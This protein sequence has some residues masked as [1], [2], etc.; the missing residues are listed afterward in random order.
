M[1]ELRT[2]LLHETNP[3]R[4][5]PCGDSAVSVEFGD[6]IDETIN[7]RVLAFDRQITKAA[8]PGIVECVPTYRALLIHYDPLQ[9]SYDAL[10]GHIASCV[11]NKSATALEQGRLWRVPVVYGGE[12]GP[13]LES[14][15]QACGS[16]SHDVINLH[17]SAIYRV[18]MLGF[19]PGFAYLGGLPQTLHLP[20]RA[21]P[22]AKAEAGTISIAAAQAAI[23]CLAG[24]TGWHVIGR[25]PVRNFMPSR[26]P[27]FLFE[28]G[29]RITF[30]AV[31]Q[32]EWEKL[33]ARAQGGAPVAELVT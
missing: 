23:Q 20:R 33:A 8:L 24:P 28:P 32:S 7:S 10:C 31:D 25:T 15:A 6:S 18:Y 11:N 3:P 17:Q 1:Q 12:F 22:I 21:T 27:I 16:T 13:D 19:T 14:V 29:D 2:P 4:I 30:I 26:E 9:V 5:L